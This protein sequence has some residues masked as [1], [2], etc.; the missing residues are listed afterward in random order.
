MKSHT[1]KSQELKPASKQ[2]AAT[3]LPKQHN[4]LATLATIVTLFIAILSISGCVGLTSAG[5]PSKTGSSSTAP[6]TLAPSTTTL[7][8]GNV[9]IGAKSLQTLTLTNSGITAVTISQAAVSGSGFSLSA[10]MNTISLPPGKSQAVQV[11]FAPKTSGSANGSLLVASDASDPS[12]TLGLSG[13]A[14][15]AGPSIT[16]QPANQSIVVGQTATFNVIATGTGA[17]AY[18]WNKNGI[19][20]SG[21]TSA[22]YTTPAT[23]NSD[24][25]ASFTVSVNDSVTGVTSNSAT[26]TVTAAPVAPSITTQPLSKSVTA[27]Q[28]ATFTVTA[29][30][31]AT[32]NYQWK[33][34][35]GAISG[36]TS[37]SYTTPATSIS[38]NGAS[39]TVTVSNSTGSATSNP[40]TLSVTAAPVA[41]SITAQPASKSV[42][43]GQ[44]AAF[45]VG[46][47]GTGTLT[48]QWKKNGSAISGATTAS[49]TTPAAT[50]SDNGASFTVTVG[51]A[52]GSTT[53]NA[54][55]LTVTAAPVAPSIT[56]QP[57]STSV[58]AGQ[59]AA[60]TVGATGTGTLT[61]Q[62][63]KN[64]SA[65]SGA[66]TASYT[67][68]A[69]TV[70]DN[71]ASFTV[72]VGDAGGSTTS[73]AATL[74]VTAA[75][76]APSI[77]AQPV[78]KSVL[79]GQTVTF[80][81]GATGTGTL[82]YQWKKNGTAISGANSVSY[83]TPLASV[84]DNGAQFT[85]T[86]TNSVGSA[87]SNPATL[88][89]G[90]ATFLLNGSTASLNFTNVSIGSNGT[91]TVTFTN[92]GNS[93]VTVSNVAISGAGFAASGVSTGQILTPGQ[94]ATLNVT[95]TP[96]GTTSVP[97]SVTVASNATN[98]PATIALSGT[99][100]QA[101]SHSATLNWVAST[102]TVAG[103]NVY[104]SPVS[105]TGYAKVSSQLIGST[106][107]QDTTV[108]T[109]QTYFYVVTSSDSSG[110]ESTFSNE[111]TAVIP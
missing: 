46:A 28:T 106:Q 8:F 39:F 92:A 42:T 70:S 9:P 2:Q 38:D 5:T 90:A 105:G 43:A 30:G 86:V 10:V 36:A 57:A 59:T 3:E 48:Y 41:P 73:N 68:P 18:Q 16:T 31:T 37:A 7:N 23:T 34:N 21:A 19:A 109:G 11:E 6:G 84:A 35:G 51:D 62:W 72:T 75:P 81:V 67:T 40:A 76:V 85:V 50:V 53:S 64:G 93:N 54:A 52:G 49:Y 66:T 89:V 83:T 1:E 32:L 24:N 100:V 79:A 108:L 107:Y 102:S 25:G 104:R 22:S 56:A 45:T 78:G 58:T 4:S 29:T 96:S 17:L 87:T 111:A 91:L 74:T 63:K 55:T 101:V 61:Y 20:I 60:F 44:T 27:G 71:G 99:G 77:T 12:L 95:F 47:T 82:A 14:T 103:Y 13:T 97:G 94:T 33:K 110:L 65:I 15:P 98:S 80:T 88:T 69:A 26:L